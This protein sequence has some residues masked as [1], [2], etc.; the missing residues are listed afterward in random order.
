MPEY[1]KEEIIAE[2]KRR[3]EEFENA[4]AGDIFE[5]FLH[6]K[7]TAAVLK[8]AGI[9]INK[10]AADFSDTEINNIAGIIKGWRMNVVSVADF[11][12]AQVTCGGVSVDEINPDTMESKICKNLYFTGECIDVD[13]I[14]GGYN[15]QWAWTSGYIAGSSC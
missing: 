8:K 2:I 14:C 5:G 13:G 7:L 3:I 1:T 11:D 6:N 9:K 15:L 12:K 10:N 4:S